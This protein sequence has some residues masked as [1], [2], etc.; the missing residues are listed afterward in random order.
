MPLFN[1]NAILVRRHNAL[2]SFKEEIL[3][4]VDENDSE[5]TLYHEKTQKFYIELADFI[6]AMKNQAESGVVFSQAE[7]DRIFFENAH[8]TNLAV[9]KIEEL[10]TKSV[11]LHRKAHLIDLCRSK[12]Y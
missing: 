1:R 8:K 3:K 5:L 10:N 4:K 12:I 2:G 9:K 11:L 6:T 7:I